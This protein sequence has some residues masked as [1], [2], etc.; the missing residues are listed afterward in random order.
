MPVPTVDNNH[1]AEALAFLIEQFKN[2]EVLRGMITSFTQSVQTLEDTFWD[3]I[4]L[5]QLTPTVTGDQED[6]LGAIV[7][8]P[9]NG[10]SDS[11]YYVA[12]LL[13]IRVNRSQGRDEDVIAVANL[14]P[15]GLAATSVDYV[16][17]WPASF[18]VEIKEL[19][20]PS[21][22][23][24]LLTDTKAAG[25][26]GMLHYTTWPPGN[27]FKFVSRYGGVTGEGTWG[28][29]YDATVGGFMVAGAALV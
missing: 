16:E 12:I 22:A 29:R 6:K 10:R 9:R 5:R 13:R 19:L 23:Q 1:V 18:L 26:Y 21:S 2:A 25:T 20:S 8:E 24:E 7:G 17:Q 15:V 28:S 4:N 27:D 3:I 11:D 14:L